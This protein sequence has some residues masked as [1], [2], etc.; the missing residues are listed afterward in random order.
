MV[1]EFYLHISVPSLHSSWTYLEA[2]SGK[3]I[4]QNKRS[5][6]AKEITN[7]VVACDR[8]FWHLS[9]ATTV[10]RLPTSKIWRPWIFC[11]LIYDGMT[12]R[13]WLCF[14]N[15]KDFLWSGVIIH[16]CDNLVVE[17]LREWQFENSKAWIFNAY[18]YDT[19]SNHN[20]V[21]RK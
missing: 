14:Q 7:I 3:L 18:A 11:L 15:M 2:V 8:N 6:T 16:K 4:V 19:S 10:K 13:F 21:A 17:C 1:R 12:C 20:H 9:K 5:E